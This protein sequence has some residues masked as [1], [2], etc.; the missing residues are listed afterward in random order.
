[1]TPR[2]ADGFA[3]RGVVAGSIFD[4]LDI[5]NSMTSYG[6]SLKGLRQKHAEEPYLVCDESQ[7]AC[8][9]VDPTFP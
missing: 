3:G 7:N 9:C 2:T 6:D 5:M 8:Y 1:M 4:T